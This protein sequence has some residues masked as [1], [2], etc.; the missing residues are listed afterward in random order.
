MNDRQIPSDASLL[1]LS[2]LNPSLSGQFNWLC[3]QRLLS[4]FWTA[5]GK[6]GMR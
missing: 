3:P 5:Q 2:R 1:G 4:V 6:K